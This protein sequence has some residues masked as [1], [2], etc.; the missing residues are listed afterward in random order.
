MPLIS[1]KPV[2][3]S[4]NKHAPNLKPEL[5]G[6]EHMFPF[7]DLAQVLTQTP[8]QDLLPDKDFNTHLQNVSWTCGVVK[9]PFLQN[10]FN[11]PIDLGVEDIENHNA[12]LDGA[13][14]YIVESDDSCMNKEFVDATQ[15]IEGD[16][17]PVENSLELNNEKF[18]KTS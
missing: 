7:P 11:A 1:L 10:K 15:L 18:L 3:V 2:Y 6:K 9:S 16:V 4:I 8:Y 12:M 5:K 17:D 13:T 14:K